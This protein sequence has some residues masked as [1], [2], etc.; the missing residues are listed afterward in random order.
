[1]IKSDKAVGLGE[2]VGTLYCPYR[3]GYRTAEA[4]QPHTA[5]LLHVKSPSVNND[6]QPHKNGPSRFLF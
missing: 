2:A 4:C 3:A 6:V 1:M 5:A